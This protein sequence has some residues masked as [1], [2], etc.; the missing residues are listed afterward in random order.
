MLLALI[1][2]L[3][4]TLISH[5]ISPLLQARTSWNRP[6]GGTGFGYLA[7]LISGTPTPH[8][9]WLLAGGHE[10]REFL[11]PVLDDDELGR[12]RGRTALGDHQEPAVR[13]EIVVSAPR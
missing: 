4:T 7:I 9:A 11:E 10:A 1:L 12:G 13:S 5:C 3:P 6:V 8:Q 2:V